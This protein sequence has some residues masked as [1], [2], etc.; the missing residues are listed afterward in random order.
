MFISYIELGD[1]FMFIRLIF[2][3]ILNFSLFAQD[4]DC[5]KLYSNLKAKELK[6]I[7][8]R[9][10]QK[11][12]DEFK[13]MENSS[14]H[15][16]YQ[17][18]ET[19]NQY[20]LDHV[21]SEHFD[22]FYKN[23]PKVREFKKMV[24]DEFSKLSLKPE[25]EKT[26][27]KLMRSEN[28]IIQVEDI[29][30]FGTGY[31]G[32]QRIQIL[33][34]DNTLKE[35]LI[36]GD[37]FQVLKWI[38][39]DTFVYSRIGSPRLQDKRN[40]EIRIHKIGEHP[41]DDKVIYSAR[42]GVWID[43]FEKNNE[44]YINHWDFNDRDQM[45]AKLDLSKGEVTPIVQLGTEWQTLSFDTD[46]ADV[47]AYMVDYTHKNYGEFKS[48]N[49]RTGE[50]THLLDEQ[51]IIITDAMKL[52]ENQLL[53]IGSRDAEGVAAIV[54][55]GKMLE[56]KGLEAGHIS[57][58]SHLGDSLQLAYQSLE[59]TISL[60]QFNLKTSN[61]SVLKS[62][63]YPTQLNAQKVHYTAV[64]GQRAAVWIVA[65]DGVELN[66]ETPMIMYG[67]GGWYHLDPPLFNDGDVM[68]WL[69][70]GGAYAVVAVPG[71][72]E[73][74]M[75]WNKLAKKGG[76]QNS[77]DSFANAGKE[78]IARG[79]T[80]SKNLGILGGSNGGLLVAGTMQSH[81]ELINAAVPQVGV[82]DLINF[83]AIGFHWEYGN[84]WLKN[85]FKELYKISPYHN[86]K[87]REYP[88]TM[89]MT[90][91]MDQVVS[92]SDNYKYAARLQKH[93]TG[94]APILLYARH[95]AAHS[96]S[97]GSKKTELSYNAAVYA[98]FAKHLGL[99]N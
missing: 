1:L 47:I 99:K 80:S 87:K 17:W 22:Y 50:I 98:F 70:A 62:F 33:N 28:Y 88:A 46:S 68:S 84:P 71:S 90:G 18:L 94:D 42:T 64:N 58:K 11:I 2:I 59:N 51:D 19:Q 5:S 81:P 54:E 60:Y 48:I 92:P 89:V 26:V 97:S 61:L 24:S 63:S 52:N 74:G 95:W 76:R 13:W 4:K 91:D 77:F 12:K 66:P 57:Y 29:A 41:V 86:I 69:E 73:Y 45:F 20:T 25:S 31:G 72:L 53:I 10:G 82:V 6:T 16:L 67:Y 35:T 34:T 3:L 9:F 21:A 38:D 30:E 14:D 96:A 40:Q 49:M 37:Y 75:S 79:M 43:F 85:D 55:N 44:F 27:K 93:Q 8:K 32:T 56:I 36:L 65:K 83:T 15:E 23:I 39:N 78:L 7:E